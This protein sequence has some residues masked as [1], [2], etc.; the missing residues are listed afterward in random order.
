M[1][2][3]MV[4]TINDATYDDEDGARDNCVSPYPTHMALK[5]SHTFA[6][7]ITGTS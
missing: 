3:D 4:N 6:K 1:T 7:K 5:F 2:S